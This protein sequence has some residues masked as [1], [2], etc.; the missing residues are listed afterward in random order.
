MICGLD[1]FA[2][3]KVFESSRRGK[4]EIWLRQVSTLSQNILRV[5]V[6]FQNYDERKEEESFASG[7]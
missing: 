6:E 3:K 2:G 4:E 1:N 5:G 7:K